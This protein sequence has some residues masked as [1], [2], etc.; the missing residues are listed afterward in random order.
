MKHSLEFIL[1]D[2]K[3]YGL[4]SDGNV[5]IKHDYESLKILKEQLNTAIFHIDNFFKIPVKC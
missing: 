3:I 2:E 4:Y 1:N 5:L